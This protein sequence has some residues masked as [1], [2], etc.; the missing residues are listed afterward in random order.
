MDM[1][2]KQMNAKLAI[3]QQC[4]KRIFD[5][6][7]GRT[8]QFYSGQRVYVSRSVQ[9]PDSARMAN[10]QLTKLLPTTPGLFKV[11]STTADVVK[12]YGNEIHR[13]G[14]KDSMLLAPTPGKAMIEPIETLICTKQVMAGTR[15]NPTETIHG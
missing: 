4:Y 3:A 2:Q 5:R 15:T 9:V 10:A 6:I 14:S 13:T 12:L 11:V 7:V 8:S 1:L